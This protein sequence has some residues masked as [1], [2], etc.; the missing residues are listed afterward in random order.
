MAVT[1]EKVICSAYSSFQEQRRGQSLALSPT[2]R[3]VHSITTS[4]GVYFGENDGRIF[5]LK[6]ITADQ[7]HEP[8]Q[9]T[10]LD[11]A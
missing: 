2:G 4:I 7:N 3:Q 11:S 1:T 10:Y 6:P 8:A 5:F 9:L